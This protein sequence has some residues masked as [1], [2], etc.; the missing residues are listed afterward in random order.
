MIHI[1]RFELRKIL[2]KRLTL[3]ALAAVLLLAV[4]LTFSSYLN[5]YSYDGTSQ[6]TGCE[7]VRIDQALAA[8]Y[9]G[10]LTD[11]RVQQML[12]ELVPITGAG[13][14]NARYLYQNALQSATAARFADGDGSWN[15]SSARDVFG[16]EVIQVG[17]VDGWLTTSQNMS[18]VLTVLSFVLIMMIAPVYSGEYSGMDNLILSSKYGATKGATAKIVASLLAALSVT[19]LVVLFMLGMALGLYGTAGLDGSILYAP[20]TYV[21]GYIPFNLTCGEMLAAQ[22]LLALTGA[23]GVTGLTLM[24]SACCKHV[25]AALVVAALVH[26]VP[27][28]LP[29]SETTALFRLLILL[30]FYHFESVTLMS[31]AQFTNGLLY[32][33]WALP[34][35]LLLIVVGWIVSRRLFAKHQVT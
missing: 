13:G 21:E 31:A 18:L 2:A 28:L 35:A 26:I 15:G 4:V 30:P 32:A 9:A 29:M 24:I 1:L 8:H 16:D 20:M 10:V 14:L 17:Y 23:L 5:K 19:A 6:G 22:A 11:A 12:T 25:L 3:F 7:A 34:V 27:V 33:V